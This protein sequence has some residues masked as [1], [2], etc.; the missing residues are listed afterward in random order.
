MV[1]SIRPTAT[2]R[3]K[4][5]V[6]GTQDRIEVSQ[7]AVDTEAKA[8]RARFA[9]EQ[10]SSFL[11]SFDEDAAAKSIAKSPFSGEVDALPA[12][13]PLEVL[14]YSLHISQSIIRQLLE[15]SDDPAHLS[16]LS[17]RVAELGIYTLNDP[18][19]PTKQIQYLG[20]SKRIGY[21]FTPPSVALWMAERALGDRGEIQQVLDPA[22]GCGSLL[23]AVLLT[24]NR[25][26][27]VVRSCRGIEADLFTARLLDGIVQ[28]VRDLLNVDCELSVICGDGIDLL[29]RQMD[30]AAAAID[31]IVMNPPYG[32]IKFLKSSLT[33]AETRVSTLRKGLADQERA[34][35]DRATV[36]AERLRKVATDLGVDSGTLDYQRLFMALALRSLS[37]SGRMA[38]ISPSS[39]LGDHTSQSLRAYIVRQRLLEELILYP[40]G[41]ALFATVNQPTA[42]AVF[43][44]KSARRSF[45][46]SIW[47]DPNKG[48]PDSYETLYTDLERLD[49]EH[50]RIPRLRSSLH[51]VYEVLQSR[52]RIGQVSYL[53]N[54]RG[55]LDQ[56]LGRDLMTA[57]PSPLRLIRGDHIERYVLR[58]ATYSTHPSYIRSAAFQEQTTAKPKYADTFKLRIIGRQCSYMSKER[59]LSFTL[60]EPRV[61]V[62]NSCNYLCLKEPA[63]VSERVCLAALT[64]I[65]NSSILEWYFR[66]YSSNNHVAN[67][68]IA[69][70]P[71]CLEDP[72]IV[73]ALA[74]NSAFL[75]DAYSS[76][77]EGG[78]S[79]L[80]LE[81][82]V[83]ALVAYGFE[84]SSK[85]VSELMS[86]IDPRRVGRVANMVGYFK[87]NGIPRGVVTGSGRHQHS[88]PS[89]SELDREVIR[90]VPQGGN[91]R[92]IPSSVP[93]K[94]LRQI[95]DM[96][97]ER[98][99]V[100]TTY[101][102]RLR[103]DQPAYTIATY[104]NRPGNG[105]N[106]HPWEERTLST[107][108][109][110]RLQSFPDYYCFLGGE[111]NIRKQV[112]NAVPPLLAHAVGSQLRQYCD[113][114]TSVDVFAG[115]GGLSLG[116]ELAGWSVCAALDHDKHALATYEF[117]RPCERVAA[118]TSGK[119]LS[120]AGDLHDP[121]VVAESLRAIRSKLNDRILGLV[122]GG[123]PCQGFSHAGWRQAGDKR[124]DLAM[125][126]FDFVEALTPQL[127]VLEN[128]E[129]LLTYNNG[130]VIRDLVLTL[131]DLGYQTGAGP[132][133]LNAEQY[134]VPQMRRRVF[135]VGS[136]SGHVVPAPQPIFSKCSGRREGGNGTHLFA[137]P[138]PITAGEALYDLPP[139]GLREHHEMGPRTIRPHFAA[140]ARG[141]ISTSSFL[142][143]CID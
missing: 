16:F 58:P 14:S 43:D 30:T 51:Q 83:D 31:C 77:E 133:C 109:A 93:S 7:R 90:H 107:R 123:P 18:R 119:T 142:G 88:A 5:S 68:E 56:T 55:E 8:L 136:R 126:F 28:R 75:H 39:W 110:A 20:A 115:A 132:W 54:A 37:D 38:V 59:R 61:V 80:P 63:A 122:I 34:G 52:T 24:A 116:L 108:E 103:P 41:A 131:R 44:R 33:N 74:V 101:Y 64:A 137:L 35:R 140:W 138:Y 141:Q 135:L 4:I 23:M 2:R 124:N 98:G 95:R 99:I 118:P 84:L 100:R 106:I 143:A 13:R 128:V 19:A 134:G 27:L 94:R 22:A 45:K 60:V 112:G 3:G 96:A 53:K 65:L 32:R 117:N 9:I 15:T 104:Y 127:V 1:S 86:E 129:G 48:R 139:L 105:T 36:E 85:Q 113:A 25:K 49:G 62:G 26:N 66:I 12:D 120:L 73:Q 87:R 114:E 71:I 76:L 46:V 97:E 67:Y 130:T 79:P 17:S 57:E 40:E 47:A 111:S 125:V 82:V 89:L 69:N 10:S 6:P 70:L 102:G 21:F 42:V 81:D 50:M 121:L 11:A 92:S 29:G 91:W 72:Q 78:R